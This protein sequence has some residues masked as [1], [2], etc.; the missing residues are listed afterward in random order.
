[1]GLRRIINKSIVIG[2]LALSVV[3][4]ANCIYAANIESM[5]NFETTKTYDDGMFNDVP[6]SAWYA[7]GVKDA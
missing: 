2:T 5:E 4:S 1:M 6:S 3:F 7:T